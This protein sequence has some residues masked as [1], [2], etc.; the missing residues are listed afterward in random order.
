MKFIPIGLQCSVPE[1][2]KRANLR[3]YSYP[4]DW[5]WTPSK[6]TYEILHILLN[7]GVESAIE[8]MTTGYA[9]YKDCSNEHYTSVDTVTDC[10]INATTGLGITH[11]TINDHFKNKLRIRFQRFMK[12]ITSNV[13]LIYADSAN[14]YF[15][16]HIDDVNYGLDATEYLLKIYELLYPLNNNIK[17]TYFCWN[18]GVK[19]DNVIK[20]IPFNY[21]NHWKELSDVIK[22]YVIRINHELT[23]NKLKFVIARYQENLEWANGVSPSIVYNKDTSPHNSIHPVISLPNVGREGHTYLHHIITNYDSLDDYTVFLQGYPF[24]HTPYLEGIIKEIKDTIINN[25]HISF[26]NI[27]RSI[28]PVVVTDHVSDWNG[29]YNLDEVYT[30]IF[31][32]TTANYSF[33]FG[34]GAQFV[35]S[36]DTILTRPKSFY[37]NM[38]TLLDKECNPPEGFSVERL[39]TM[40]F[41]HGE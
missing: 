12:D 15:N 27:S 26:R 4:F 20:Y 34:A 16:Y 21:K 30:K 23:S 38:I 5:L 22:D 41:T 9:Y 17:I 11:F 37:E 8:Y 24:D 18:E 25:G 7:D 29:Y 32:K 28:L 36:R 2:I 6:T 14:P 39:W 3:E 1:G 31:G 35:V 10:Q 40:V 13:M 19:Y 33:E